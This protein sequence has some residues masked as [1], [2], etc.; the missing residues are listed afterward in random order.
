MDLFQSDPILEWPLEGEARRNARVMIENIRRVAENGG[1][2][3]PLEPFLHI[4]KF[5][6]SEIRRIT[7]QREPLRIKSPAGHRSKLEGGFVNRGTP[8]ESPLP[9]MDLMS[10]TMKMERTVKGRFRVQSGRVTLTGIEG[11]SVLKKILE[12]END[13]TVN[14]SYKVERLIL[15]PESLAVF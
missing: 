3:L 1:G 6:S 7:S 10:A 5:E 15:K 14:M 8:L 13:E 12:Q 4:L 2:T 11:M 9:R